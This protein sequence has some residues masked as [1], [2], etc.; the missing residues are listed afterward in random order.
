LKKLGIRE[1][2]FHALRHTFATRAIECGIDCKTVASLM[3]HSNAMITINRYSHS[4]MDTKKK[5]ITVLP[6][7]VGSI[8]KKLIE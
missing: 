4:M 5:A 2:S 8:P 3:G 1:L 7:S 6:K